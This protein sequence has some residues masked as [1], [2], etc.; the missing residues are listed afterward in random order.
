LEAALFPKGGSYAAPKPTT[1]KLPTEQLVKS[2]SFAGG[3][4]RTI[5]YVGMLVYLEKRGMVKVGHTRFYGASLGA[6]IAA[7][8]ILGETHPEARDQLIGGMLEYVCEVHADWAGMWGICGP[9][10]RGVLNRSLPD[11]I[12]GLNGRLFVTVT[13]LWPYPHCQLVSQFASKQDLIETLLASQFIPGWT[14]GLFPFKLWRG[15]PAVDGGVF[16]N[17]PTPDVAKPC[18][19]GRVQFGMLS[20]ASISESFGPP[21]L[22]RADGHFTCRDPD[23]PLVQVLRPPTGTSVDTAVF[24]EVRRGYLLARAAVKSTTG[25]REPCSP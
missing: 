14:H 9:V 17:V 6:L 7:G 19:A 21:I 23:A 16:D 10:C 12:S 13:V 1:E 22:R 18:G 8:M 11:D 25:L 24:D 5:S 3:G 4:F 2:I 20:L 15:V